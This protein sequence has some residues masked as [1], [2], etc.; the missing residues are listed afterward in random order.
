MDRAGWVNVWRAATLVAGLAAA[1]A[2]IDLVLMGTGRGVSA[3]RILAEAAVAVAAA[4][5]AVHAN[6][7][8][9][10]LPFPPDPSPQEAEARRW[11]EWTALFAGL[12]TLGLLGAAAFTVVALRSA[13]G[14]VWPA[15]ATGAAGFALFGG[16]AVWSHRRSRAAQA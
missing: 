12:A 4:A 11:Q 1:R 6:R 13:G 15:V 2:G 10:S 14:V 9:K 3:W 16:L 8:R 7:R 5:L